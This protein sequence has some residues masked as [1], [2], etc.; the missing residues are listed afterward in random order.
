VRWRRP[1]VSRPG[2]RRIVSADR[3]RVRPH[4]VPVW[5]LVGKNEGHGFSKKPNLDYQFY[6][7]IQFMREHLLK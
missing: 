5:L 6:A 7:T 2:R 3:R 1:R 4:G